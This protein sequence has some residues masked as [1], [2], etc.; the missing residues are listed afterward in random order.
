[1]T[2]RNCIARWVK[3]NQLYFIVFSYFTITG[4]LRFPLFFFSFHVKIPL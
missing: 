3:F 1:M 4:N 2:C